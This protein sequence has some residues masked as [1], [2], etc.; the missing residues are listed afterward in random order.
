MISA[1]QRRSRWAPC[2]FQARSCR[3][4]GYNPNASPDTFVRVDVNYL[5]QDFSLMQSVKDADPG[6]PCSVSTSWCA[7]EEDKEAR[8]YQA[9]RAEQRPDYHGAEPC[10]ALRPRL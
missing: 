8:D 6:R 4:T 5:R 9:W 3:Q 7:R 2:R 1:P 10:R